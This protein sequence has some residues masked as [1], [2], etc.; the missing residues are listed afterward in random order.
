[1]LHQDTLLV[2]I[3]QA[4]Y[5]ARKNK[6][7]TASALR[8][9]LDFESHLL[10]LYEDIANRTY[11]VSRSICFVVT[12]PLRREV[13][14]GAFRDRI[15]HHLLFNYIS[16]L[17]ERLFINDSY[18]C[19][20]GRGTSYG[21]KR[22]DRFIRSCSENYDKDCYILKLDISGYFMGIDKNIL[23]SKI[24]KVLLLPRYQADAKFDISLVL[25]LIQQVIYNNPTLNCL[26]KGRLEDWN[27]L[28]KNK[29]LFNVEP[30]KGLPIGNLT[31][32]LFG[33]IYL[34]DLDYFIVHT[35][36]CRYYGRYVDDFVIVHRDKKFLKSI[37]PC[38]REYLSNNLTLQLH[39]KKIYLQHYNKGVKFLGVIIKPYRILIGKRLKGNFYQCIRKWNLKINAGK[40]SR[41]DIAAFLSSINSYLGMM[42]NYNT[43][44]LRKKILKILN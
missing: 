13:F 40:F 21:I 32:Q 34:N 28:P 31:S 15:V 5:D 30:G 24:E 26:R 35:L 22:A 14:A 4:Y 3:F 38:I 8:F 19:R 16:P 1:M 29:S 23:Y 36:G 42:K 17:F 11:K 39:P 18:S 44:N 33:N 25:W 12:K 9:E 6:R 20:L 7:T 2:D 27:D 10:R 43:F 37:I 41:E